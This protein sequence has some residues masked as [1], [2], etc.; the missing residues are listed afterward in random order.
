MEKERPKQ[1]LT[2]SGLEPSNNSVVMNLSLSK[3]LFL[4]ARTTF[5]FGDVLSRVFFGLFRLKMHKGKKTSEREEGKGRDQGLGRSLREGR[6]DEGDGG[7]RGTERYT[8]GARVREGCLKEEEREEEG[9]ER[10]A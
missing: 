1:E 2:E 8:N 6:S 4:V 5:H 7:G 9:R 10:G 3:V